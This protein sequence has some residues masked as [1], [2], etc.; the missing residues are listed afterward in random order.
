MYIYIYIYIYTRCI[1][2]AEVGF[3]FLHVHVFG[4]FG[5]FRKGTPEIVR[6]ILKRS[7]QYLGLLK[8]TVRLRPLL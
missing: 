3:F 5:A 1:H 8:Q 6:I 7:R 4:W 2:N